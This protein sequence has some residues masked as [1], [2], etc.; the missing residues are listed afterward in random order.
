MMTQISGDKKSMMQSV[1]NHTAEIVV[2]HVS[3]P[4]NQVAPE[5]VITFYKSLFN[6]V[7]ECATELGLDQSNFDNIS[8]TMKAGSISAPLSSTPV[9]APA[10]NSVEKP[11]PAVPVEESVTDNYIVCL[12]DGVQR[13]LLKR[14]LRTKFDMTPEEYRA[15]WGLPDDYPMAAKNHLDYRSVRAKEIGLGYSGPKKASLRAQKSSQ[16]K[17]KKNVA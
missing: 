2:A 4:S 10:V 13:T 11:T 1:L 15:K 12:E 3:N 5:E 6:L 9:S 17:R 8:E 16:S 7:K 14:Y